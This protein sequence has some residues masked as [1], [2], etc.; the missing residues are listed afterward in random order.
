[1]YDPVYEKETNTEPCDEC[2]GTGTIHM[3]CCGDNITKTID[4]LP[5]CPTCLE[6]QGS[7]GEECEYC[8]GKGEVDASYTPDPDAKHDDISV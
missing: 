1:M 2:S 4:M 6:G 7:E 5:R 3:S 8:E